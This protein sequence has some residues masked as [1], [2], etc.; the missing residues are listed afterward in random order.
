MT[1]KVTLLQIFLF[2]RIYSEVLGQS[3]HYFD[4]N[5][6]SFSSYPISS[7]P[8]SEIITI[9]GR[10]PLNQFETVMRHYRSDVRKREPQFIGFDIQDDNLEVNNY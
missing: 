3:R 10:F 2:A 5:G 7:Y 1:N 9:D 6:T 8:I 4:N